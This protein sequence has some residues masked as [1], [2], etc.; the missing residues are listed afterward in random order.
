MR[1]TRSLLDVAYGLR[2]RFDTNMSGDMGWVPMVRLWVGD[3]GRAQCPVS[4]ADP[5]ASHGCTHRLGRAMLLLLA[6]VYLVGSSVVAYGSY[7]GKSTCIQ[8]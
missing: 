7:G 4:I 2:G 5:F 8:C 3:V 1:L 6:Y